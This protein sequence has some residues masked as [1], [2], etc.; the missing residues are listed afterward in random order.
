[1]I[2]WQ[3]IQN[4]RGCKRK[5]PCPNVTYFLSICLK[6]VRKPKKNFRMLGVPVRIRT[7]HLSNTGLKCYLLPRCSMRTV[8]NSLYF[9][10]NYGCCRK[11]PPLSCCKCIGSV[12]WL[13]RAVCCRL[14]TY[15]RFSLDYIISSSASQVGLRGSFD[16]IESFP[17]VSSR[18]GYI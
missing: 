10:S 13:Y 5:G 8:E 2:S 11:L 1:M 9:G 3:W 15:C 6:R 14:Y 4:S 17:S 7:G 16:G 18:F 12:P